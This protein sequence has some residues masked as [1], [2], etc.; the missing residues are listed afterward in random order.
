MLLTGQLQSLG[1]GPGTEDFHRAS[2]CGQQLDILLLDLQ[3]AAFNRRHI[4]NIADQVLQVSRIASQLAAPGR[5]LIAAAALGQQFGEADDRGHGRA[6]FVAHIG[7]EIGFGDRGRFRRQARL[8]QLL[9]LQ[10][11]LQPGLFQVLDRT[12]QTLH[13]HSGL[14]PG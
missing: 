6:N 2:Y 7:E 14:D 4:E 5:L 11:Q 8:P 9:G 3:C 10:L 12:L 13:G 1:T